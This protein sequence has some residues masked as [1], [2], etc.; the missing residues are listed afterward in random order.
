MRRLG[1]DTFFSGN[2]SPDGQTLALGGPNGAK[3]E[4]ISATFWKRRFGSLSRHR[5]MTASSPGGMSGRKRLTGSTSRWR[6][7]AT[8][9]GIVSAGN[10]VC[11]TRSS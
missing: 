8:S 7:A 1:S 6:I 10:G 4:A 9:S 3:A 5:A 2:F 11:L